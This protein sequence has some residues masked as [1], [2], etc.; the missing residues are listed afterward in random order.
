MTDTTGKVAAPAGKVTRIVIGIVIVLIVSSIGLAIDV[1]RGDGFL[2]IFL[3][4]GGIVGGFYCRKVTLGF[5]AG[6]VGALI[7]ILIQVILTPGAAGTL[8]NP[9]I[10]AV[11]LFFS[12]IYGAVAAVAGLVMGYISRRRATVIT[13]TSG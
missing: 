2:G 11:Y 1:F 10:L 8:G 5:I 7:Q 3:F 13:V 9:N 4:I 12:L 6:W